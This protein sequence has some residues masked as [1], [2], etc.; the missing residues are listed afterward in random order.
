MYEDIYDIYSKSCLR[1]KLTQNRKMFHLRQVS[2]HLREVFILVFIGHGAHSIE[3]FSAKSKFAN[4][5]LVEC[6]VY[7]EK[8][9]VQNAKRKFE[10]FAMV[11]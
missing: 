11:E 8:P 5:D 10:N 1:R 6:K 7:S 4:M 3:I 2:I 9:D